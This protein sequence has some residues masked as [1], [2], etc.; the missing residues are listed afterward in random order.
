MR[1]KAERSGTSS[2][3]PATRRDLVRRQDR[4]AQGAGG[5]R[6]PLCGL[7]YGLLIEAGPLIYLGVAAGGTTVGFV[8]PDLYL[9]QRA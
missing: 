5:R 8:G 9:Y 6:P 3:S 7:A 2:T 4:L 1:D